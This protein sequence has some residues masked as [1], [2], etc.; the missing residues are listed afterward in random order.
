MVAGPSLAIAGA[1]G[2]VKLVSGAT[3]FPFAGGYDGDDAAGAEGV[4]GDEVVSSQWL[5]LPRQLALRNR[6]K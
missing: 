5:W 2:L 4:V 3:A 1:L 6:P